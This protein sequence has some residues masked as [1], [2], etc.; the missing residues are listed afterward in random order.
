MPTPEPEPGKPG[1]LM[2]GGYSS[3]NREAGALKAVMP[4]FRKQEGRSAESHDAGVPKA[5]RPEP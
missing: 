3:E 1:L 2:T 5:G 4:E